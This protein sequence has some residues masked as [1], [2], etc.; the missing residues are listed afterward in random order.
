MSLTAKTKNVLSFL[1][2]IVLSLGLLL[3]VFSKIDLQKTG[4][5]LRTADLFYIAL[6]AVVFVLVNGITLYR[7]M[8]FIRALDLSTTLGSVVEHYLYG[9][10]G[11]L[12][13]PTAIGGDIIKAVGLC[14]KSKQKPRVI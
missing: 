11:N 5:I 10:F 3:Y 4:E 9:L 13:L 14:K 6:A 8:V 1:V 12:F 2:R 7:W